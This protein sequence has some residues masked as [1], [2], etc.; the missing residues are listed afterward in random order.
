M[1]SRGDVLSDGLIQENVAGEDLPMEKGVFS[2]LFDG[3]FSTNKSG[4]H[5]KS[6]NFAAVLNA[7][8]FFFSC[9]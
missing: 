3:S 4:F 1:Y 7:I 9:K 2:H 6:A 5:G 8:R